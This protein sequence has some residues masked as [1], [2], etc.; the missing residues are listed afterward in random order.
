[1]TGSLQGETTEA[2]FGFEKARDNMFL[3]ISNQLSAQDL[4]ITADNAPGSDYG[5]PKRQFKPSDAA[6]TPA[7]GK[8]I[9]EITDHQLSVGDH[10]NIEANSLTFTCS[11]DNHATQHTYPRSTD[12]ISGVTTG[13]TTTST[14]SFSLN[15][16]ISTLVYADI[17]DARYNALTGAM[18]L[19]I[20]STAVG[21]V[22]A[23][24]NIVG[25]AITLH[26]ILF[27]WFSP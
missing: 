9:L 11:R 17:S 22:Y 16:G 24:N 6:Y 7:D 4:T 14:T 1:M 20:G 8:L 10:I 21:L 19:S 3:A 26:L 18:T 27:S 13:I 23:N 2:I 25:L 5:T 15:V 12:P